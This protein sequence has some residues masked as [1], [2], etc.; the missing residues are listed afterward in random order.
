[1]RRNYPH[2]ADD[3]RLLRYMYAGSQVDDMLAAAPART[4][5]SFDRPLV[6]LVRELTR[7]S[8][9]RHVCIERPDLRL[10]IRAGGEAGKSGP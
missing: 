1:L 4:E 8:K 3:E 6:R 10:R 5:Y 7:Q 9:Y 2:A